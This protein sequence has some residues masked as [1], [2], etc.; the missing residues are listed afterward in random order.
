MCARMLCNIYQ[1][2][3][4]RAVVSILSAVP[5]TYIQVVNNHRLLQVMNSHWLL[6]VVNERRST[7][8]DSGAII[9][10]EQCI[11]IGQLEKLWLMTVLDLPPFWKACWLSVLFLVCFTSS[12]CHH[13]HIFFLSWF[14]LSPH[15]T[16][17][18]SSHPPLPTPCF[19]ACIVHMYNLNVQSSGVHRDVMTWCICG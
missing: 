18:F 7:L 3:S 5:L 17:T 4:P 19:P 9:C 2:S 11:W 8:Q 13:F 14:F 10:R 15:G 16:Y 6:Q 1:L 12:A